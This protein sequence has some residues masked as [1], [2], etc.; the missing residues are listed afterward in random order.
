M[1][2]KLILTPVILTGNMYTF[3]RLNK[4]MITQWQNSIINNYTV[5][6]TII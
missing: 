5:F 2:K 1:E 6:Q 3:L 4:R